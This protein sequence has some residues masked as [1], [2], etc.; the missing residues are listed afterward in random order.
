MHILLADD[1]AKVRFALRVLLDRQPGLQVIDEATNAEDLLSEARAGHP[2]LVLMA[3]ELAAK[4]ARQ[5]L[6]ALHQAS[7]GSIVIVLSGRPEA[8]EAALLAGA[9]AFVSKGD[10]P[11][12][13]LAA[14]EECCP[15][16]C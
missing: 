11:E 4:N 3:W 2:D 8:R 16:M 9:H 12:K 1:Q 7:P 14:I 15:Q 10:P 13:L 5:L 6:S